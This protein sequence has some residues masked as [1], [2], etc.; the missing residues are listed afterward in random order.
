MDAGTVKTFCDAAVQLLPVIAAYAA[1]EADQ[2][3]PED[4]AQIRALR[5]AAG[6]LAHALMEVPWL[7]PPMPQVPTTPP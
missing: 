1:L 4:E 6:A 5:V 2:R 7:P 3:R